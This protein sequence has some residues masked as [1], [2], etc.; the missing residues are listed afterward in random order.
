MRRALLALLALSACKPP[1][2]AVDEELEH[3]KQ[4]LG[5]L[6]Q[7][8]VAAG[9]AEVAERAVDLES[10]ATAFCATP[11]TAG[12]DATR[13]AW[14]A[15]HGPWKR[16]EVVGFGPVVDEPYRFGPL[17]DFWPVREGVVDDLI[18]SETDL[19]YDSLRGFGASTRG[20]PVLEYL[21]WHPSLEGPATFEDARRCGYLVA[22]ASD[23]RQ[24]TAD[25]HV[26]WQE[27]AT[28]LADP[29]SQADFAYATHQQVLDEWVNRVLFALDD[30]RSE[31]LGKPLGDTSAGVP[32]PEAAESRFSGRS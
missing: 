15:V 17:L 30:I 10:A 22:L 27:Y 24:N 32:L 6:H 5:S 8:V 14:M 4:V 2:A 21:L 20:L 11:D 19:G 9:Y 7:E 23:V 26:A 3:R 13:A 29:G 16:M 18:A 25:L 31:K 1:V 12:L 28:R